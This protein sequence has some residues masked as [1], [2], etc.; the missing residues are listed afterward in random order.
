MTLTEMLKNKE[1]YPNLKGTSAV[2]E[3]SIFDYYK[4]V[5][6]MV[7]IEIEDINYEHNLVKLK[8][9]TQLNTHCK[10]G[11]STWVRIEGCYDLRFIDFV[12]PKCICE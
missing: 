1:E 8:F 4:Q 6:G 2:Y 12:K 7:E 10:Q 3:K 9:N 5:A 11:V